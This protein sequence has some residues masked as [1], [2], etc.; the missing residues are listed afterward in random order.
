MS[1]LR[2]TKK[3][4]TRQALADSAALLVMR[5]GPEALTVADIAHNAGVSPRTF[6]NYFSSASGALFYFAAGVVEKLM[7]Q[8]PEMYPQAT[9][10]EFFEKLVLDV[11]GDTNEELHSL[12]TLFFISQVI[13]NLH[14][15]E[16][17]RHK[18]QAVAKSVF[19]A[20]RNREPEFGSIELSVIIDAHIGTCS[21]IMKHISSC[22]QEGEPLSEQDQM[23]FVHR[24]FAGLRM[25]F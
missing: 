23:D 21:L 18:Y 6:H 24:A 14:Q 19:D 15:S 1:S 12:P 8:L 22:A 17:E 11:L 3:M 10:N 20:F 9:I 5:S 13:E 7:T 2:E 16:E 4:A 25:I